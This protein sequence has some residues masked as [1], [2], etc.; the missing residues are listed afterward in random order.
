MYTLEKLD[1]SLILNHEGRGA[2]KVR[3]PSASR[4]YI[5]SN[6]PTLN[7]KLIIF[8]ALPNTPSPAATISKIEE[9]E[10]FRELESTLAEDNADDDKDEDI[11]LSA[12]SSIVASKTSSKV[13]AI[14]PPP[15]VVSG[16][17]PRPGLK[18]STAARA[19]G[20]PATKT[21]PP[22]SSPL[23]PPP[24]PPVVPSTSQS[25]LPAPAAVQRVRSPEKGK[26]ALAHAVDVEEEELEFGQPTR[27]A[28]R[29]RTSPSP[30]ALPVSHPSNSAGL[31]SPGGFAT[32]PGPSTGQDDEDDEDEWDEVAGGDHPVNAGP[33]GG[34]DGS[35]FG[36]VF[37][38]ADEGE[39]INIDRFAA[40]MDQELLGGLEEEDDA[41][42]EMDS[43]FGDVEPAPVLKPISL[44][45]FAGGATVG[46]DDV[47]DDYSSSSDESDDD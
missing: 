34:D 25:T 43:V 28:K 17:K 24:K 16:G 29:A 42:G 4:A 11:P 33:G 23:V 6:L 39:E 9:D 7:P 2:P 22:K 15:P 30:L 37:G 14:R 12:S 46:V 10:L 38:D 45:Q 44:N 35:I 40:E 27:P 18:G 31:S 1:S 41:D 21:K 19:T 3:Q 8:L 36:D 32:L 47:D 20:G 13:E 26:P 5:H